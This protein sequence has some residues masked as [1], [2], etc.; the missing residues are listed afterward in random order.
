MKK[1]LLTGL[2][3]SVGLFSVS[4]QENHIK[5]WRVKS[6]YEL[7]FSWGDADDPKSSV[8]GSKVDADN[9]VRFSAFYNGSTQFHYDFSKNAGFFTGIGIR[10][11][12]FIHHFGDSVTVKQREYELGV[13]LA[14]KFGNTDNNFYLAA[15]AEVHMMFAYKQKVEYNNQKNK[16]NKWFSDDAELFNYSVFAEVDM[17]GGVF[18]RFRYYLNDFLKENN[19]GISLPNSGG[20]LAYD[21]SP[22]ELMYVAIGTCQYLDFNFDKKEKKPNPMDN[23]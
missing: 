19:K 7:I 13:P 10:N 14:I 8:N 21:S 4:A 17:P 2:V 1:I 23:Q 6:A 9:V 16:Y 5:Q 20:T 3:L 12:G 15:G 22:S 11:I 18:V